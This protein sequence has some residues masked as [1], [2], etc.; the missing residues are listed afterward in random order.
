MNAVKKMIDISLN[1]EVLCQDKRCGRVSSVILNPLTDELTHFVLRTDGLFEKDYLVPVERIVSS[2]G[3]ALLLN[4][5]S[6]E[7]AELEP[8][9]QTTFVQLDPVDYPYLPDVMLGPIY[10]WPFVRS[11]DGYSLAVES[12]S[13]PAHELAVRRGATVQ[14]TDGKI[15]HVDEFLVDPANNHVTHLVMHRGHLWNKRDVVIPISAVNRVEDDS[16]YLTLDKPAVAEL[17]RIPI[18]RGK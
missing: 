6:E 2:S 18:H 16:V 12:E 11:E 4:C 17:P 13:V 9:H 15:G 1:A 5:T 8:F 7:V 14:A 3:E 10:E